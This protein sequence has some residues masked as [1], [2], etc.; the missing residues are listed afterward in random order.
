MTTK[1]K[2]DDAAP[3][4]N[5][6]EGELKQTQA[7]LNLANAKFA[8]LDRVAGG[9]IERLA[10]EMIA[11]GFHTLVTANAWM[12]TERVKVQADLAAIEQQL[13]AQDSGAR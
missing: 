1:P 4:I 7:M 13:G 10:G 2:N 12:N 5:P 3:D 9:M 6:L 11:R 8:L